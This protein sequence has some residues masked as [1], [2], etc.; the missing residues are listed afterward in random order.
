VVV[1]LQDLLGETV[2]AV[3]SG[4]LPDDD[5]LV[6][7]VGSSIVLAVCNSVAILEC[8]VGGWVRSEGTREERDC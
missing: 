2:L 4:E 5:A 1:T 3:I 6:Y 7:R 8:K